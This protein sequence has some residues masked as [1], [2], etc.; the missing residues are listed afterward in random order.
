MAIAYFANQVERTELE[1]CF[2]YC[3]LHLLFSTDEYRGWC[4]E[5]E[6]K[7]AAELRAKL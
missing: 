3:L 6:V 7:R 5:G 4:L 1:R 2:S